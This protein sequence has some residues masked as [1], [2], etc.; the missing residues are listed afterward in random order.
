MTSKSRLKSGA[1]KA[2]A[3][4][5]RIDGAI[6]TTQGKLAA[7]K[8]EM[9]STGAVGG[10]GGGGAPPSIRA[11]ALGHGGG[12]GGGGGSFGIHERFGP[13]GVRSHESEMIGG[14][15]AGFTV[16]EALKANADL[17]QV[18]QNL[19]AGGVTRDE[20]EKAT[21]AA[22]G[23][24]E[25]YGLTARDVLQ[26]VNEI[27]N[28]LNRGTTA[29]EG[30]EA[31][32]SHMDTLASAANA[33]KA[34][35]GPNGG[36]TAKELYDLVKSAEFRNAIG[37]KDFDKSI[38]SMVAADVAT[39]GIVTPRTFLQMSQMLKGALPGL[40]DDYLYKIMPEL[41]QE[42]KGSS[43]GTAAASLYQQLIA[44]QMRTKGI[45]LLAELGMVDPNKV[46]YNS[47][48]MIK[49]A[50]PGFYTDADTFR[51]DPMKSIANIIDA[52]N[53]HGITETPAQRDMFSQLFGNR[54]AAQMAM[55]LGYQYQR[56]ERGEQGIENTKDIGATS[57]ELLANNPYTQW[58]KFTSAATNAGAALG[59]QLMPSATAALQNLT[60]TV[61][62]ASAV[63]R[64]QGDNKAWHDLV[65]GTDKSR[66]RMARQSSRLDRKQSG[67]A[68][69]PGN[70]K[71]GL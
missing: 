18:Q 67:S 17:Q 32:L 40:S 50:N 62:A 39:G 12:H 24:G 2:A 51:S 49:A 37:D 64:G 41:A 60:T 48:G 5:G 46:Q 27:R 58:Q 20:I 33:L 71:L 1:G 56:L 29:N 23:I 45:N 11:R 61:N 53:K 19:L 14:A 52:M 36:D 9:R 65:F 15:V 28:P 55:T 66:G 30:V 6:A 21:R 31:A 68:R 25:K 42:F 34:Q 63:L 57:A 59:G 70:R 22:Y 4:F 47:I 13:I 16:W 54:N 10:I 69:Q 35:G 43:A 7:L 44:G 26:S 3:G 38:K 8:A